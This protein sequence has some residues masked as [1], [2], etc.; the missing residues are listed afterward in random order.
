MKTL[1]VMR[2]GKSDWDNPELADHDR[3]LAS[4]G[5]AD[6]TRMG[7]L[8]AEEQIVPEL[9]LCSTAKRARHTAERVTKACD[10]T[11]EL[12]LLP[13]FYAAEPEVYLAGLRQ[14]GGSFE[15]VMIIGHN[16]GLED[17]VQELTGTETQ[18]TTATIALVELPINDWTELAF[19]IEGE[20]VQFWRPKDK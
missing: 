18:F 16:P 8:L 11:G 2:H 10:Y 20:L 1:L 3:P 9:I 15:R 12:R 7:R 4:R 17:F 6:A 5:K 19:E 13:E 14:G